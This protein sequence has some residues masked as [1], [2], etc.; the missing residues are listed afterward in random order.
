MGVRDDL[1][2]RGYFPAELPP[3]FTTAT[4]PGVTAEVVAVGSHKLPHGLPGTFNL[5]RQGTLRRKLALCNPI[6]QIRLCDWIERNLPT[7]ESVFARSTLSRSVPEPDRRRAFH[8][9]NVDRRVERAVSRSF[10][11]AEVNTDIAQFYGSIYTHSLE[12]ALESRDAAKARWRTRGTKGPGAEV[13]DLVR[14]GQDGQSVGL[15]IGPDASLLLAEALLCAVDASVQETKVLAHARGF[16]I[17]DDYELAFPSRAQADDALA[18]VQACLADFELYLNPRK[19]AVYELPRPFDES[20]VTQLKGL[21]L[22]GTGK[23]QQRDLLRL[24][25]TATELATAHPEQHVMKYALGVVRGSDVRIDHG[26][27]PLFQGMLLGSVVSTPGLLAAVRPILLAYR[28]EGYRIDDDALRAIIDAL[29]REHVTLRHSSEVAEALWTAIEFGLGLEKPLAETLAKS[30]D[31]A[32]ALLALDA[33][34]RGLIGRDA[35][36]TS[37][38]EALVTAEGLWRSS[39][40]LVYEATRRGWLVG[41]EDPAIRADPWFAPLFK[42]HV[43]FYDEHR[44]TPLPRVPAPVEGA[45]R[46]GAA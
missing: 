29:V 40:L 36:D 1:L 37:M 27:W 26:N 2:A 44:R 23:R 17:V 4:L 22:G 9:R 10:A 5:A 38:W 7:L 15:P 20:W 34:E 30:D 39:W 41:S 18:T 14:A 8:W 24:F 33:R 32:I 42:A 16:R 12:W 11:R 28:D 19:T 6:H 13:D 43:S 31:A 45:R 25:D 3:P 21:A 46:Y 35:L